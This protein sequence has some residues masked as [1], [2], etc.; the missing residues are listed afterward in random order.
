MID[1]TIIIISVI[2]IVMASVTPFINPFFRKPK[3]NDDNGSENEQKDTT[4]KQKISII[5]TAHDN[6]KE[7][8]EHLPA[9]LSQDYEAEYEIIVVTNKSDSDTEDVLKRFSKNENLYATFIPE[10]SRYMSK[11]KLA[12]TLGVK[13]AKY[14][15]IIFTDAYCRPQSDKWLSTMVRNCNEDVNLIIGYTKYSDESKIFYHLQRVMTEFYL[16]RE[17]QK[18]TAYRTD[19]CNIMFRKSEFMNEDGYRDNLKY[20]RG[21]YDFMVNKYAKKGQTRTEMSKDAWL[22]EDNPT[23]KM[24]RNKHLFYFE[25]RKHLK[26]SFRHRL[27][28]NTDQFMMYMNFLLIISSIIFSI[29]TERWI[30]TAVAGLSLILT[31]VLRTMICRKAI[32]QF[33]IEIPDDKA[34]EIKTVQDIVDYIKENA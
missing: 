17:A 6:A 32:K 25:T 31:V 34:A 23:L 10:T 1:N 8:E 9:F 11:K 12:V 30:I 2:L 27:I 4:I 16:M 19:G 22:I 13:A 15:W 14:E 26:R 28:F 33:D 29:I 20:I 18:S 7:L 24:W 5:I 21:E 3:Q